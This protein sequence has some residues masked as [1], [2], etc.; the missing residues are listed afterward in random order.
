MTGLSGC[1]QAF[2]LLHEPLGSEG[3]DEYRGIYCMNSSVDSSN[4]GS[5]A[6]SSN[7]GS[8]AGSSNSGSD[9]GSSNNG[10]DAGSSNSGS[11]AGSSNGKCNYG[12]LL[13]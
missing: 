5:D 6:G 3:N 11:D 10:S 1:K 12:Y 7:S 2:Q 4:N 9:A 8:D 13:R